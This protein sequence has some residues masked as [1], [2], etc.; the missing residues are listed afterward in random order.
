MFGRAEGDDGLRPDGRYD[1]SAVCNI[2]SL[3]QYWT[4]CALRLPSKQGNDAG[5]VGKRGSLSHLDHW[6]LK[7]SRPYS[8]R[9]PGRLQVGEPSDALQHRSCPLWSLFSAER[10]LLQLSSHGCV[11]CYVWALYW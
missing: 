3:D 5:N 8:I 10:P 6:H 7:H 1:L 2:E 9:L 11:L 4:V